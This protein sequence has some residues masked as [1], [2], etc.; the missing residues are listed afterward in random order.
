MIKMTAFDK[1]WDVVKSPFNSEYFNSLDEWLK[2][3]FDGDMD[4]QY[5]RTDLPYPKW[6]AE[7]PTEMDEDE[8]LAQHWYQSQS[9]DCNMSQQDKRDYMEERLKEEIKNN[10]DEDIE[11]LYGELM[12]E[13]AFGEGGMGRAKK[14]MKSTGRCGHC[15]GQA[16]MDEKGN[17]RQFF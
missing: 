12:D 4:D 16:E 3:Y 7:Q 2:A 11:E 14:W 17:W 10:P 5:P 13:M 6:R 15:G 9:C 8:A 1:A